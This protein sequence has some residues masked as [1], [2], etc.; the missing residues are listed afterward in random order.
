MNETTLAL[1]INLIKIVHAIMRE[2]PVH[3]IKHAADRVRELDGGAADTKLFARIADSMVE[4]A[5]RVTDEAERELDAD[6]GNH[7][8]VSARWLGE[9]GGD[10]RDH[11][12]RLATP[13]RAA[14]R[15]A[16]G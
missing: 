7:A 6:L 2:M 5:E 1:G 13:P 10:E 3:E 8:H 15:S 9:M 11:R 16:N 12:A 14:E 4:Y